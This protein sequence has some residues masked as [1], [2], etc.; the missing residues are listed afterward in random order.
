[1]E[2]I[3]RKSSYTDRFIEQTAEVICQRCSLDEI[4]QLKLKL[5]LSVIV[6]NVTKLVIIIFL[7]N[8]TLG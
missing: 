1:M 6:I 2:K 3:S 5:G 7:V 4:E 8:L